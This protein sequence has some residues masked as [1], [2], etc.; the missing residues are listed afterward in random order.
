M[1]VAMALLFFGPLAFSFLYHRAGF[2]WHP[3]PG[4]GGTLIEPPVAFPLPE[5][6][7]PVPWKLVVVEPGACDVDCRERA[8][9]LRQLHV[10][11]G[12]HAAS[13]ERVYVGRTELPLSAAPGQRAVPDED[14][15]LRAALEPTADGQETAFYLVD[16]GNHVIARYGADYDGREALRDLN[17]LARRTSRD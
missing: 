15:S 6:E 17:R 7:T 9:A 2:Q 4:L 3:E 5:A 16:P 8:H 10:A 12:R 13:F 11:L 1:L 14:G